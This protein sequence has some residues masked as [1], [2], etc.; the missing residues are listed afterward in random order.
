MR[1]NARPGGMPRTFSFYPAA[2]ARAVAPRAETR[3]RRQRAACALSLVAALV[4]LAQ[5]AVPQWASKRQAAAAAVPWRAAG[6]AATSEQHLERLEGELARLRAAVAGRGCEPAE[7]TPRGGSRA[8]SAV[9][10]GDAMRLPDRRLYPSVAELLRAVGAGGNTGPLPAVAVLAGAPDGFGAR[11]A[12]DL[13][14]QG[15]VAVL[16]ADPNA[17]RVEQLR[18]SAPAGL[19]LAHPGAAGASATAT[20]HSAP[21][22]LGAARLGAA[23]GAL[24]VDTGACDCDVARSVLALGVRPAVLYLAVNP[25]VPPP[26]AH[27]ARCAPAAAQAA[28]EAAAASAGLAPIGV[29]CSVSYAASLLA[30]YGYV[31]V[32]L[33]GFDDEKEQS[34]GSGPHLI[35]VTRAARDRASALR[36]LRA[37]G[38]SA[39]AD[40]ERAWAGWAGSGALGR[41]AAGAKGGTR[42]AADARR[43]AAAPERD[44]LATL[45]AVAA[46]VGKESGGGEHLVDF[47]GRALTD[48]ERGGADVQHP[49]DAWW[50]P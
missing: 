44:W 18:E 29:G 23:P 13:L 35:A 43:W 32:G 2:G 11:Q 39:R 9:Y 45:D 21:A 47:V 14:T 22:I 24:V 4:A 20:P 28:A 12:E 26:F 19:Q 10:L 42:R 3:R 50:H 5:L 16:Y 17:H 33:R 31:T 8:G 40:A 46:A 1:A 6:G 38:A 48:E 30:D 37:D 41:F 49:G 25:W 15:A 27:A 7:A 34:E 36:Q